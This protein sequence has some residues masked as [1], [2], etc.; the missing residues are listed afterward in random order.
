MR[1]ASMSRGVGG[2]INHGV[3][4]DDGDS[5]R[6]PDAVSFGILLAQVIAGMGLLL[7]V[8]FWLIDAVW[9]SYLGADA[10]IGLSMSLFVLV[11]G[12]ALTVMLWG[13]RELAVV[14]RRRVERGSPR[15]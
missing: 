13:S 15:R 4:I 11:V 1:D 12:V 3:R 10:G 2:G 9:G 8:L 6:S 14:A 7:A 5:R